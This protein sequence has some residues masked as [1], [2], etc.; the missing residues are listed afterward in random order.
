M[1]PLFSYVQYREHRKR[2]HK[3]TK[4]QMSVILNDR[5]RIISMHQ[6]KQDTSHH[7]VIG[8]IKEYLGLEMIFT[9]YCHKNKYGY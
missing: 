2:K 1:I 4:L 6:D 3:T 5:G 9:E 7:S 8:E